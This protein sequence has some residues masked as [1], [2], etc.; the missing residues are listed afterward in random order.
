MSLPTSWSAS[1]RA[2]IE[3]SIAAL[4]AHGHHGTADDV[5][6]QAIGDYVDRELARVELDALIDEGIRSADAGEFEDVDVVFD[7]IQA[8]LS[9]MSQKAA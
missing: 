1:F 9:A 3:H 2:E 4:V 7:H 6:A 8:R 5:I